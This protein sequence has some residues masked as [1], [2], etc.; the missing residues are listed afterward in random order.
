LSHRVS[1]QQI[2]LEMNA[3][4]KTWQFNPGRFKK[5]DPIQLPN[6]DTLALSMVENKKLFKGWIK[7]ATVYTARRIRT[8]SNVLSHIITA[9]KV[10][11]SSLK[12]MEAPTLL[13][14]H[15]LHPDDKAT[16]DEA[17]RQEYQGLLDID[18]WE[19]ITEEEYND[20]KHIFGTLLPTMAIS[21]IKY[22]GDG[23]P[24]RAK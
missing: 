20:M 11:A 14:H 21:T 6:F 8:T 9:R 19:M 18:T 24:V 10:S 13:K 22:Y 3:T 17:Y 12:L 15:K 23:K 1:K 4:T 16:W 5:R 2:K 7:S